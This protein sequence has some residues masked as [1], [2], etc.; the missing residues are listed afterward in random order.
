MFKKLNVTLLHI[1]RVREGIAMEILHLSMSGL[2]DNGPLSVKSPHY[3][4]LDGSSDS[5]LCL[6][7]PHLA[8]L[9]CAS[10]PSCP[11]WWP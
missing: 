7:Q 11:F 10:A 9:A 1:L 3:P 4:N 2:T 5:E 6:P 8:A